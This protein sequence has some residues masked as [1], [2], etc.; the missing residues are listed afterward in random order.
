M[1]RP[2]QI[3]AGRYWMLTRRCTQ[4]LCLLRPDV[5]TNEIFN[6]CLADASRR[7]GVQ[8]IGYEALSNHYHAVVFDPEARLP[9]FMEH[10]N[11]FSARALNAHWQR[12][13][14]V[15]S[16]DP[17]SAVHLVNPSDVM[18]KLL[19]TLVNAVAANLVDRVAD[20]PGASSYEAMVSGEPIRVNRPTAFFRK[21]GVMPKEV[22][23]E[24]MRPPGYEKLTQ[25]EWAT[26]LRAKI[27]VL[28]DRAREKRTRKGKS[29][30]GSQAVLSVSPFAASRTCLPHCRLR[31]EVACKRRAK[32]IRTLLELKAFRSAHE[33]ARLELKANELNAVF[34]HG[35]YRMRLMGL[36]C[37]G[38]LE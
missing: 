33:A 36:R 2:R 13:E 34:P 3:I 4:G 8:V 21:N 38:P 20:W 28:E 22:T 31:P 11:K 19:Y 25:E 17:A 1:S 16:T 30:L 9:E 18:A 10:L 32:R 23:L 6:Y 24:L 14:N 15:W 29:V 26:C 35:T 12:R 7:S 27:K 5:A 37:A